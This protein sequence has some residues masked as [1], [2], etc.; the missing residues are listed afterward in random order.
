MKTL[1]PDEPRRWR[2]VLLLILFTFALFIDSLAYDFVWDDHVL[3]VSNQYTKYFRYLPSFFT[4]D[5][6]RLTFDELGGRFYRPFLALSFLLDYQVWGLNPAG[7]HLTNLILHAGNSLLAYSL[8]LRV[9]RREGLALLAAL[10][11]AAHPVHVEVVAFI[12]GRV[13][14]LLTM[15]FLLS[16]LA[17]V[18]FRQDRQ[19][20]GSRAYGAS[21]VFFGLALLSKETAVILPLIVLAYD[22]LFDREGKVSRSGRDLRRVVLVHAPFLAVLAAYLLLRWHA[23]GSLLDTG[24]PLAGIPERLLVATGAMSRYLIQSFF[25]VSLNPLYDLPPPRQ[26]PLET[27][28]VVSSGLLLGAGMVVA[29]R[30]S[31]LILWSVLWYFVTL[32][33]ASN[34]V[35]LHPPRGTVLMAERYLYLP[36]LGI[37]WFLALLLQ[38]AWD[39]QAVRRLRLPQRL[40][41]GL[42][43]AL[44]ASFALLA[45]LQG[46]VWRDNLTLY[47]RMVEK[48]PGSADAHINLGNALL[49]ARQYPEALNILRRAVHLDPNNQAAHL[50]LAAIFTR[51]GR[52]AEAAEALRRARQI[53]PR[54]PNVFLQ[55]AAL[56]DSQGKLGDAIA[57]LRQAI[58]LY[59]DLAMAHQG[60]GQALTLSG[61][62]RAAISHFQ[63][64]IQISPDLYWSHYGLGMLYAEK[65]WDE[66]ALT[67]LERSL[68]LR[69]DFFPA[70]REH[71]LLLERLNR[72]NQAMVLWQRIVDESPEPTMVTEASAHLRDLQR[73]VNKGS[74][75]S[76]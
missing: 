45:L 11:F 51:T 15:F 1:W 70:M 32:L 41:P 2:R 64:A 36:S 4:Q 49:A 48:N 52:Y 71:A 19:A 23:I 37:C 29:S 38:R 10:L 73:S 35:P 13:D 44:A 50:S 9:L 12:S 17:F 8:G 66:L 20:S 18:R 14:S 63:R 39:S 54:H 65:G 60:L 61:D 57:A 74:L 72:G 7:Y 25:P 40:A 21:L 42:A 28:G 24:V 76:R 30:A 22:L 68:R 46:G 43:A 75:H 59:P 6:S 34:L 58:D 31:R 69:P 62:S 47:T 53:N 56:A 16:V 3:I 26:F 5:F 27:V 33:P 55:A 67:E